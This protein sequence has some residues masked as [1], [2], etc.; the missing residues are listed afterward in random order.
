MILAIETS[1]KQGSISVLSK[2][3]LLGS[4]QIPVEL[5]MSKEL[6]N[7]IDRL[8]KEI[9]IDSG[10][11]TLIGVSS[12]PGSL[13]GIRIGISVG[14]GLAFSAGIKCVGVSLLEAMRRK[15]FRGNC[16]SVISG[17]FGYSYYQM[18]NERE[19]GSIEII[20]NQELAEFLSNYTEIDLVIEK[21]LL[22]TIKVSLKRKVDI[23]SVANMSELI[24]F[25]TF[26]KAINGDLNKISPIYGKEIYR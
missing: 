4:R 11:L 15:S 6:L 1:L 18:F 19:K 3:K 26:N 8:L 23:I 16:L 2:G 25:E 20:N 24:A 12:G 13:T 10:K 9:G 14:M 22:E 21:S 7:E 17:G 5:P